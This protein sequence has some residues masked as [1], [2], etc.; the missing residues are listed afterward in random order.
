M[1]YR[2][3]FGISAAFLALFVLQSTGSAVVG[4]QKLGRAPFFQVDPKPIEPIAGP[5]GSESR[6]PPRKPAPTPP[7]TGGHGGF[8]AS[9]QVVVTG[10]PGSLAV[11]HSRDTYVPLGKIPASGTLVRRVRIS[12]PLTEMPTRLEVLVLPAPDD[13]GLERQR[14]PRVRIYGVIRLLQR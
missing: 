14:R 12:G 2:T 3:G 13:A 7:S 5:S 10:R 9:L 4:M 1:K 11:F 8:A 6:Q